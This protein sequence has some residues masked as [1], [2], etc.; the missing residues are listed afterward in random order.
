MLHSSFIADE[1]ALHRIYLVITTYV[2][3]AEAK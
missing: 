1:V 2:Q 3:V